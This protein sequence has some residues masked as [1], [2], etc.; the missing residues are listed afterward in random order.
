MA[1]KKAQTP[2]AATE[3]AHPGSTSTVRLKQ[4]VAPFCFGESVNESEGIHFLAHL[5]FKFDGRLTFDDILG[6]S[7]CFPRAQIL[8]PIS[9]T[10][11]GSSPR[12]SA[13]Q[14]TSRP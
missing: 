14:L 8:L 6:T 3:I 12:F 9:S 5:K 13:A 7:T 2:Q 11:S 10:H 1:K 4:S